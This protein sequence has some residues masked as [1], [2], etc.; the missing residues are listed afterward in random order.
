MNAIGNDNYRPGLKPPE[1]IRGRGGFLSGNTAQLMV[2]LNGLILTIT[3]F[4]TLS[5][6]I[7]EIVREGLLKTT[8]DVQ[9]HIV[10]GY[11]DIERSFHALSAVVSIPEDVSST[12]LNEYLQKKTSGAELFE[13]IYWVKKEDGTNWTSSSLFEREGRTVG[14]D[15]EK[16]LIKF[17]EGESVHNNQGLYIST[18]STYF[19]GT[20]DSEVAGVSDQHFFLIKALDGNDNSSE[21]LLGVVRMSNIVDVEWLRQNESIHDVQVVDTKNDLPIYSYLKEGEMVKLASNSVYTN[22]FSDIFAGH[23]FDIK[24]D[25]TVSSRESFLKKIPL[26]MLLFG[27]TLTLIGTL[28]VRNNQNQSQK[29]SEMNK[30]LAHKNFELSQEVTERERLNH[31]IQK[32]ASENRAVIN[33]VS[34]IIFEVGVDGTILFL[35]DAWNKV[36]GFELDRSIGRNL[37]ELLYAQDQEEQRANF[38]LLVKGRKKSYRSFTRLRSSDGTFRSVELAVSMLR[39]DENKNLRVVGTITDVEERHRAEHALG[40]AEKKYRTIVENAAGGIYQV[41]PEGQF[42]S[43]NPAF[44]NIVG[45]E[46]PEEVLR[47]ID[48]AQEDLYVD[49]SARDKFLAEVAADNISKNFEAQITKK[50]GTVIWINENVR[51]VKDDEGVLLFFEGSMDDVDQRKKAEIALNEA[52]IESDLANRAKSEFLA[53]MSHELRTPLNSVIG[54]AEIIKNEALGELV[55]KEYKEYAGNI[56]DSGNSLLRVINEILDVSKI[57]AGERTLSEAVI[58]VSDLVQSCL[59][60]MDGKIKSNDIRIENKTK[61]SSLSFVGESQA[62]KQMVLNLMSNSVKFSP[63]NGFIMV[64]AEIDAKGRLRLSITDTGIGMDDQE[65][66]KALSPFGQVNAD[67]NRST[68][69]T[70]LG[71]TLVKSLVELH[72]GGLEMVSQKGI[73]TTATLIFPAKRVTKAVEKSNEEQEVTTDSAASEV[74]DKSFEGADVFETSNIKDYMASGS[75]TKP[76]ES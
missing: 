54:F 30:E 58:N 29:L 57:E 68:S 1:P 52:K 24:V 26:L 18:Q 23:S 70:G 13:Q 3:A 69:G 48:V 64:D 51:P 72:G 47:G 59:Q 40:E 61:L 38:D 36:T 76:T 6:F 55:H 4:A 2:F 74:I 11:E 46:S 5:V 14:F 67:H 10:D 75:F 66:E 37:F 41:T 45:Y 27:M 16:K 33:A 43:A 49:V 44:A 60:M 19:E 62:V 65:L 20:S 21:F 34:D 15:S 9:Q 31:V 32:S 17:I 50:D 12:K 22:I 8:E 28:Y 39:Q 53:N 25:A 71:L 42:L 63:S 56:Y 73:G 7:D 35:N